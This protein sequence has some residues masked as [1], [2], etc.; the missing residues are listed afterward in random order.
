VRET[1]TLTGGGFVSTGGR[2]VDGCDVSCDVDDVIDVTWV[3]MTCD[4]K[5]GAAG[6][7]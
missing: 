3:V 4:V 1:Q 6:R 2:D 7:Q 5:T